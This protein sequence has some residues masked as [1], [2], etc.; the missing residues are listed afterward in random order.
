MVSSLD[1]L[2]LT[3]GANGTLSV[4]VLV[5]VDIF[6]VVIIVFTVALLM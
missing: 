2:S 5:C 4:P 6:T 3:H 1:A